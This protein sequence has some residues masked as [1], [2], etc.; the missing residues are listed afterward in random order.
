VAQYEG[1]AYNSDVTSHSLYSDFGR[2][3]EYTVDRY[4]TWHWYGQF[5]GN[6]D[7]Y[8]NGY[9]KLQTGVNVNMPGVGH[10]D[11]Y[12]HEDVLRPHL[13]PPPGYSDGYES[14][15]GTQVDTGFQAADC[16][17]DASNVDKGHLGSGTDQFGGVS[18]PLHLR[19]KRTVSMQVATF[20]VETHISTAS[21]ITC[22]NPYSRHQTR[23]V[24]SWRASSVRSCRSPSSWVL[25]AAFSS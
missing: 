9:G 20:R 4:G 1:G 13:A 19:D 11:T 15:M 25:R 14:Y 17:V 22:L 18:G 7:T 23:M 24:Q 21:T 16:E 10:I 8:V 12:S 6:E 5:S 3:N 2:W